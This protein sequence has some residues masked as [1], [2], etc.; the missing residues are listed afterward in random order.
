[1]GGYYPRGN[2]KTRY[3]YHSLNCFFLQTVTLCLYHILQLGMSEVTISSRLVVRSLQPI[4]RTN[5][6]SRIDPSKALDWTQLHPPRESNGRGW[7]PEMWSGTVSSV[8]RSS[9]EQIRS[10]IE[11]IIILGS[12]LAGLFILALLILILWAVSTYYINTC[13]F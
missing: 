9:V 1:V 10:S 7:S 8:V 13:K 4:Y 5:R 2:L 3:R 11:W 6:T 12:V